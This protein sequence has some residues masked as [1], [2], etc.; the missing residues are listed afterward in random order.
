[1]A[2][3]PS[4]PVLEG[5]RSSREFALALPLLSLKISLFFPLRNDS[6]WVVITRAA[7]AATGL[8]RHHQLYPPLSSVFSGK[9]RG[10]SKEE[11]KKGRCGAGQGCWMVVSARPPPGH[12]QERHVQGKWRS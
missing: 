1:M 2:D 9:G 6:A 4:V 11:K 3:R 8:I 10:K 7:V 12:R 5:R